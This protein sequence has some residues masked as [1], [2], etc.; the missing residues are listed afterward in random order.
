MTWNCPSA[1]RFN[2]MSLR[3]LTRQSIKEYRRSET[4][5][6]GLGL[7]SI[8]WLRIALGRRRLGLPLARNVETHHT[9]HAFKIAKIMQALGHAR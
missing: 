8:S 5:A 3:T 2:L 9:G 1:F 6:R 7:N 4:V